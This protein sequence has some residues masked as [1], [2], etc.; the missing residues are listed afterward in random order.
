MLI[1]MQLWFVLANSLNLLTWIRTRNWWLEI[2]F[3]SDV[4]VFLDQSLSLTSLCKRNFYEYSGTRSQLGVWQENNMIDGIKGSRQT[5]L[6]IVEVILKNRN[7]RAGLNWS[8]KTPVLMD[9]LVMVV[10]EGKS[11]NKHC[12]RREVRMRSRGMRREA[13]EERFEKRDVRSRSQN[14]LDDWEMTF[15]TS[16]VTCEKTLRLVL[17]CRGVVWGDVSLE[18]NF[19]AVWS[20]W[21]LSAARWHT[22]V[23]VI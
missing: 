13:W 18:E 1:A 2:R 12:L 19:N 10:K 16:L 3:E 14:V 23:K 7:D 5:T 22:F 4:F 9:M 20:F 17:V 6:L 8:G 15:D 11:A 21:I